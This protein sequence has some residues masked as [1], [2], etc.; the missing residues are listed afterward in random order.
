MGKA[1]ENL[2][3]VTQIGL[4]PAKSVFQVHGIDAKGEVVIVRKLRRGTI[5]EFFGQL[6]PC[7]MAMEACS[8]A[9]H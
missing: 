7:V 6:A 8:S 1:T 9:H 4:D 3:R 2:A 5:L